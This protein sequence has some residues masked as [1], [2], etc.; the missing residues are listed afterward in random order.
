MYIT[1][2]LCA[3]NIREFYSSK[4]T[5]GANS[6]TNQHPVFHTGPDIQKIIFCIRFSEKKRTT[7]KVAIIIPVLTG[8]LFHL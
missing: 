6:V 5:P 4:T 8:H 2:V 1:T 7:N 3:N